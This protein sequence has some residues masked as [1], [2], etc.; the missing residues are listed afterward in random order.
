MK[1]LTKS[2]YI[3]IQYGRLFVSGIHSSRFNSQ[4]SL[5]VIGSPHT[6]SPSNNQPSNNNQ[7]RKQRKS[8]VDHQEVCCP[9]GV[10][11]VSSTIGGQIGCTRTSL[12]LAPTHRATPFVQPKP[13]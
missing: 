2:C 8:R 1:S 10:L 5:S 7:A 9:T 6:R 4:C 3:R 12:N 11:T 13:A